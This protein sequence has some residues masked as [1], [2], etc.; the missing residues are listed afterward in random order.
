MKAQFANTPCRP[1]GSPLLIR[2][3]MV[4]K[5]SPMAGK[6]AMPVM[7]VDVPKLV[8]AY[9]TNVPDFSVK[10]QRVVFGTSGHRG[11]AFETTFNQWFES[12]DYQRGRR[13]HLPIYDGGLGRTDSHGPFLGL[14]DAAI[15]RDERSLRP[16]LRMRHRS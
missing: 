16:L 13:P 6:P 8:T 10:G 4:M 2:V 7:L 5:I 14:C 3:S 1:D 15:D 12:H 11:S 9:Y